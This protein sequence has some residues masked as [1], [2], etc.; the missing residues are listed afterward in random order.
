MNIFLAP[1]YSESIVRLAFGLE[2]LDAQRGS[3]IAAPLLVTLDNCPRPLERWRSF[4]RGV[5]LDD[6][7]PR[8]LRHPSGRYVLIFSRLTPAV[9]KVRISDP[10]RRY[11]AR[12]FRVDIPSQAAVAGAETGAG[13]A[14]VPIGSRVLSFHLHPGANADLASG[15]TAIRGRILHAGRPVPWCRIGANRV[16]SDEDY[17]FTHGDERG[18]FLLPLCPPADSVGISPDPLSV[19]L[20]VGYRPPELPPADDRLVPRVD[21]LWELLEEPMPLP[22]PPAVPPATGDAANGRTFPSGFT[23]TTFVGPFLVTAGRTRP[24]EL[25]I[26]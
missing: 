20:T 3:R 11:V 10:S 18:E 6:L 17:G 16:S 15:T 5:L 7:L 8:M 13:I 4:G 14:A 9:V 2:P 12:R 21:P 24:V 1:R 25:I 19:S 22:V 26:P 23:R